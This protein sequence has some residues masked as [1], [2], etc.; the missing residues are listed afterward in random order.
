MNVYSHSRIRTYKTCK[1]RF[2]LEYVLGLKPLRTVPAFEIGTSYHNKVEEILK[3]GRFE[4]SGDMTDAMA[5]AFR[6]Y[7]YPN[8][9]KIQLQNRENDDGV[10]EDFVEHKFYGDI[11]G[12]QMVGF[13]DAMGVDGVPME[14]K[15]TSDVLDSRYLTRLNWDEQ[16]MTYCLMFGTTSIRYTACKKPTIRLKKDESDSDFALRCLDW[17]DE[18]SS[19]KI[20]TFMVYRSE[21]DLEEFKIHLGKIIEEIEETTHY[22][23]NPYA[24]GGWMRCQ[25]EPICLDYVP[26]TK[27]IDFEMK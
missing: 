10:L 12:H 4:S 21:K 5:Y 1:R 13:A 9:P 18:D 20:K 14:H 7:V 26:Q 11:G 27:L 19:E 3:T 6:K 22:Y 17:Y 24:C 25:Y 2:Y 16:V 8:V 23:R 15:T